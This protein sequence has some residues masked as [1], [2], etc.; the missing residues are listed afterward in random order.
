MQI[1]YQILTA[2]HHDMKN[3]SL[4]FWFII[5]QF[6]ALNVFG[7]SGDFKSFV[8]TKN[9]I[10]ITST[11]GVKLRLQFYTANTVRFQWVKKGEDFFPDNHYEMVEH[12]NKTGKFDIRE[13][14]DVITVN[15]KNED[16]TKIEIQKSC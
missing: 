1:P 6:I 11:T 12:H 5:F 16:S 14:S 15:M 13:S 7:Q 4:I 10:L 2:L 3:S 9:E 8:Q